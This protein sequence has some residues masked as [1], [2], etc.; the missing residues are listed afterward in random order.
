[1]PEHM[2]SYTFPDTG[3]GTVF[4]DHPLYAI[5]GDGTTFLN[6]EKGRILFVW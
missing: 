1:M 2:R 5:I 4:L 3:L 6:R